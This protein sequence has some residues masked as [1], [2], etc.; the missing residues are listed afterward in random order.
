MFKIYMYKHNKMKK[1]VIQTKAIHIHRYVLLFDCICIGT[2]VRLWIIVTICMS[3]KTRF[4]TYCSVFFL[5]TAVRTDK[6][7]WEKKQTS[8]NNNNNSY[9]TSMDAFVLFV[10][11]KT[12]AGIKVK[13]STHSIIHKYCVIQFATQCVRVC[14]CV[15]A[16]V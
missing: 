5:T 1:R 16:F 6:L 15:S 14:V 12:Y 11:W 3:H 2:R 10:V 8:N 13:H 4:C 7:A 9:N